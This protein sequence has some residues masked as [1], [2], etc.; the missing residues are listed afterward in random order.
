MR[1]ATPPKSQGVD[2]D[3]HCEIFPEP[4]DS[5]EVN[6]WRA[7]VLRAV[8]DLRGVD[9]ALST[10][11][12]NAAA[13]IAYIRRSAYVWLTSLNEDTGSFRYLK[14]A[15]RMD[16]AQIQYIKNALADYRDELKQS[17]RATD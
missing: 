8:L 13:K 5:P 15:L 7:V 3:A 6:L 12:A 1:L 14:D 10:L 17:R 16:N 9:L 4:A 2:W 11:R